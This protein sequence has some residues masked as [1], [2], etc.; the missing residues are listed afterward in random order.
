MN[1]VAEPTVAKVVIIEIAVDLE[2]CVTAIIETDLANVTEGGGIG[3]KQQ[4]IEMR[5]GM[6]GISYVGGDWACVGQHPLS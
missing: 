5:D 1:F 6:W 2:T 3:Q 4:S